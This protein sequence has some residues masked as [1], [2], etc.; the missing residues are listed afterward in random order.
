MSIFQ[1]NVFLHSFFKYAGR[2][3][4][5][6]SIEEAINLILKYRIK[7]EMIGQWLYCYPSALLGA[8]LHSIGFWYSFKHQAW[9]YS[10]RPKDGMADDENLDEIKARL[11][12]SQII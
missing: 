6:C 5:I 9:V 12:S 10:G 7:S 1:H 3:T 11:G 4:T 8:Q 2:F